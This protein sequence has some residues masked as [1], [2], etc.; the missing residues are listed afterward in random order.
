[1]IVALTELADTDILNLPFLL[2]VFFKQDF[3][4]RKNLMKLTYRVKLNHL[5]FWISSLLHNVLLLKYT[6]RYYI[7]VKISNMFRSN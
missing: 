2:V 6:K 3:L 4:G 1:M 5:L 7:T